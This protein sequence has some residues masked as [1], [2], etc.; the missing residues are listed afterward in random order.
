MSTTRTHQEAVWPFTPPGIDSF[1]GK[2]FH[3]RD[4]KTPEQWR[5]KRVVVVG[6]GNSGGDIAVEL[7]RVT[8]Q[9]WMSPFEDT[10]K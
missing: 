5:N 3:S 4:Y 6:I 10:S 2:F 9:V 7:S 8:K 1:T